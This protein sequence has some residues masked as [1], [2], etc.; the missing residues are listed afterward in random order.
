MRKLAAGLG[1]GLAAAVLALVVSHT[2]LFL[3]AEAKLYDLRMRSAARAGHPRPDIVLVEINETSLRDLEPLVGRWPWP[4]QLHAM[5]IDFIAQGR[6]KVIAYDVLFTEGDSRLTFQFGDQVMTGADSDAALAES[7]SRAGNV[8]LLAD[9]N[10][11]GVTGT[12]AKASA[13][14]DQGDTYDEAATPRP[15]IT[16]P[17]AALAA[18]ARAIG[19][20]WL[21][22]DDDGVARRVSPL[23]RAEGRMMPSLGVAAAVEASGREKSAI[24][25][26]TER[27]LRYEAPPLMVDGQGTRR[28]YP[29]YDARQLL[30]ASEEM[31]A[32]E[33]PSIDPSV[34]ADRIVFVG[35]TAE[36]LGD[37]F[38]SPFVGAGKMPGIFMHA[39]VADNVLSDRAMTRV[40]RWANVLILF[41]PVALIGLAAARLPVFAGTGVS[42]A[43]M[44]ALVTLSFAL[45][46][47]G[48]WSFLAGPLL[49]SALALFGGVAYQYFFEDREKRRVKQ[50]F[51]RYVS[52]DVFDRL[53]KDPSL[54][55]LGGERRDM[56]VLFSDIRGFTSVSEHG[57]PEAIVAQLNEYF[58]RM[59]DVVFA[60]GGTVDKFVG[61]MVMALFGAPVAD[62]AHADRAVATA[63][64]MVRELH[65]LNAKWAAEGRAALD[66]GIGVNSGDM[67]AG[68]I[69][70]DRIMSYTVIGDAVNLGARLES[71]NKEYGTR[72]IIS[73][74]TR[75]RLTR[76]FALRPLGDVVVKGRSAAVA[77]FAIDEK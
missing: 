67:I 31:A 59:V 56:S 36:G 69:G 66:I 9:A 73:A 48:Y 16:P 49:G 70:S 72:I 24:A 29:S 51:G 25:F 44:A 53:I 38:T 46:T 42:L 26:E 47:R 40:P 64:E 21:V 35:V 14:P 11:E 4:R 22:L 75:D 2:P 43:I 74:A 12:L 58:G 45:F 60:N 62:P 57:D 68:N 37:A 77:I 15:I 30:L 39:T 71:L 41:V 63:V 19:H 61:D 27:L 76:P 8:V 23:I 6:P 54:A 55:S 65:A 20:N 33:T 28:P 52:R 10:Y 5:L 1:I 50:L 17:I 13:I 18:G 34:F 7:I 32:G 3:T